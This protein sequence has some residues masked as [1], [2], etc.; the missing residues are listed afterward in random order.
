MQVSKLLAGTA[1][2]GSQGTANYGPIPKVR[3]MHY[4]ALNNS[5]LEFSL[6]SQPIISATL[7]IA[8][9]GIAKASINGAAV[10]DHALGPWTE[11][12]SR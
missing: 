4:K 5:A 3:G 2:S 11:F 12:T 10:S 6:P 8:G 1:A 7:F 9:L